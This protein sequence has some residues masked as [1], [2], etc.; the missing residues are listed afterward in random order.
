MG[1]EEH[2]IGGEQRAYYRT[3]LPRVVPNRD[4]GQRIAEDANPHAPRVG[5]PLPALLG[6]YGHVFSSFAP[7]PRGEVPLGAV[8]L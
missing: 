4:V 5:V 8:S 6:V 3:L 2:G 7:F 1:G